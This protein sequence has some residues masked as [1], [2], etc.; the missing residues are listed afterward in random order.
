MLPELV[1]L[2]KATWPSIKAGTAPIVKQD[3]GKATFHR[4]KDF[5]LLDEIKLDRK[6][7][8]RDLINLLRAR[9]FPPYPS[10]YFVDAQGKKIYVRIQLE[11]SKAE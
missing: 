2:F 9:T 1:E 5:S 11:R 4:A 10:A 8:A 3:D 7:T 6:Y